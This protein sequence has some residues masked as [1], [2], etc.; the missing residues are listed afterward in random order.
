MARPSQLAR[1]MLLRVLIIYLTRM[2]I[3]LLIDAYSFLITLEWCFRTLLSTIL[4]RELF[5]DIFH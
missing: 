1:D 5:A 4:R 2:I 3:Q